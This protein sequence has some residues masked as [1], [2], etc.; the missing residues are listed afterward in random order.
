MAYGGETAALVTAVFWSFNSVCFTFAGKRVGSGTVN[1]TRLVMALAML[2][3]VHQVAFGTPFP[4]HAGAH[5]LIALG[6]SGLIGYALGDALLFEAFL[7]LGA[8]LAMLIM[9]LSPIISAILAW[10][11]LGQALTGAKVA[12][13]LVTLGGIA[14]VVS[15]GPKGPMEDRPKRWG[16]GVLM[17]VGGA[18]GQSLGVVL[19]LV[20]MRGD[21]SPMS[22]NL[23][24]VVAGTLAITAW[25][26]YR[27]TLGGYAGRLKDPR[28]TL[29]IFAGA[30]T[31]PVLGVG[32]CLY[33]IGHASMGVATTL[34]SLSPVLLLPISAWFFKEHVSPRAWAGTV[35][36]IAGATALF[37]K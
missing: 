6:L 10:L 15:E 24:R 21:F 4:F 22:A 26:A 34:M 1:A 3:V 18:L 16:L 8:R 37:W 36:S 17:A 28:A 12:A 30:A 19:S 13:I 11:F 23:I 35:L 2:V 9:T 7:L 33:A 29:W 32:L 25:F 14:W 27:G 5:R 20:G 31:G